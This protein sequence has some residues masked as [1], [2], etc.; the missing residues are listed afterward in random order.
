MRKI[1]LYILFYAPLVLL[2]KTQNDYPIVYPD[3]W[4]RADTL[5]S[6]PSE[7]SISRT[8]DYTVFSV[9]RSLYK[10]STECL[11]SLVEDD[12]VI[13]AVL[14]D[15]V[16]LRSTGI[17]HSRTSNDF[18]KWCIYAYHSGIRMDS[19]KNHVL[20]LGEQ[21]V[22]SQH[23]TDMVS[24][25]LHAQIESE[26]F[27]YF[28]SRVPLLTSAK[29]QTYLALKYG[30]TLDNAPYV[31][32]LGDTLWHPIDDENYYHRVIGIGYDT[33]YG[34][35]SLRSRSKEDIAMII[36]ADSLMPNEYVLVGDDDGEM[37]WRYETIGEFSLQR[38]WRM[39][40][41][42]RHLL[43]TCAI[44]ALPSAATNVRMTVRSEIDGH[45]LTIYPDSIHGDSTCY[46]T[47]TNLETPRE[48][49]SLGV[50]GCSEGFESAAHAACINAIYEATGL[51]FKKLPVLPEDIKAGLAAKADETYELPP[52]WD[53]SHNFYEDFDDMIENP[54]TQ[55]EGEVIVQH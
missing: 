7:D 51:R 23:S 42:T 27:A 33:I 32:C 34:W 41:H 45:I 52:K 38:H 53:M 3:V 1:I 21:I 15:G 8:D 49:S 12:T 43:H 16:F 36:M 35:K 14:T 39:R 19:T 2:A 40:S 13:S 25:T 5:I 28:G 6:I 4:L 50:S 11:W 18:S 20:R 17:L 44:V 54:P 37:E 22:P 26:E 30:I 47:L 9:V 46:F 48:Y 55:F 10:D 31:S 24:D 29:F